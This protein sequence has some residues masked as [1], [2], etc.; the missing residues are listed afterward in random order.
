MTHTVLNKHKAK[1]IIQIYS[2]V[3]KTI[4]CA[5]P[6]HHHIKTYICIYIYI[7]IYIY[8]ICCFD[9]LQQTLGH[10]LLRGELHSPDGKLSVFSILDQS[11]PAGL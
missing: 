7:Y 9:A 8:I 10:Y 11:L 3:M 2:D 4:Q 5:H 1:S 6:P